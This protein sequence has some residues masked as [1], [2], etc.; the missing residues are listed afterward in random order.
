MNLIHLLNILTLQY[1][2]LEPKKQRKNH[3]AVCLLA[4]CKIP[5]AC[6]DVDRDERRG[7]QWILGEIVWKRAVSTWGANIAE[8]DRLL[9][10][11][12]IRFSLSATADELIMNFQRWSKSVQSG[13]N[14]LGLPLCAGSRAEPTQSRAYLWRCEMAAYACNNICGGFNKT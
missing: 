11:T 8:S 12:K 10:Y 4:H 6:W 1:F 14:T 3:F 2:F 7:A 5:A 9:F 13:V